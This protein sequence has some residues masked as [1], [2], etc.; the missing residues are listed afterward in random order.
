MKNRTRFWKVLAAPIL[1]F[2]FLFL[3]ANAY[4]ASCSSCYW[5]GYA[6]ACSQCASVFQQLVNLITRTTDAINANINMTRSVLV[7]ESRDSTNSIVAAIEKST[8]ATKE[9]T[10]AG[11]NYDAAIIAQQTSAEAY[12]N[13]LSDQAFINDPNVGANSCATIAT[14]EAAASAA[15]S[16]RLTGKAMTAARLRRDLYTSNSVGAVREATETYNTN[17]CSEE[18][19]RRGRCSTAAAPHMQAASLNAGSLL[20]PNG[21]ETYSAE[22]EL[23]AREY[24]RMVTNAVPVQSLPIAMEKSEA[25]KRFILEQRAGAAIN[26]MA[27]NSLDQIYAARAAEDLTHPSYEGAKLSLISLMKKFVEERFSDKEY[28]MKVEGMN[29]KGLLHQ[30]ATSMAFKNWM[31]YHAYLQGERTEGLL[32]T[33]LALQARMRNDQV[34]EQYRLLA[35]TTK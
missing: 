35:T 20:V 12:D 27:M 14:T 13:F 15:T 10:Q 26:S 29:E 21:G 7:Q 8:G 11:L 32:A 16:S 2:Y 30:I 9:L 18:D 25:G 6:S 28:Q 24:I 3:P 33:T 5:S 19:V 22:E 4:A 23:A 31:S 34:L 1:A 17:F